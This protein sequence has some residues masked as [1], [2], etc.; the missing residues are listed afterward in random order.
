MSHQAAQRTLGGERI[1]A[2]ETTNLIHCEY[3]GSH[4]VFRVYRQG[5]FQE[6][7]Y[8]IF[9]FFPWRCKTCSACML[10]RSRKRP[11]TQQKAYLQLP[12]GVGRA[13]EPGLFC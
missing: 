7:I 13:K 10:L 6:R 8:P 3:C 12:R 2:T 9:G 4:R 1:Q 5:F 11:D